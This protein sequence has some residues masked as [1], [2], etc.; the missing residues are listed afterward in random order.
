MKRK[1]MFYGNCQLGVISQ[2]FLNDPK[3]N[4]I[5]E[6]IL[7]DESCAP[8]QVWRKDE[9]LF[10]VWTQENSAIQEEIFNIV[11]EKL[12]QADIFVFQSTE[13]SCIDQLKTQ[14]LCDHVSK[15]KNICIPNIRMF[16]YCS[17]IISLKPIVDYVRTK[18]SDPVD[19]SQIAEYLRNSD[20]SQLIAL[21]EKEYPMSD[22]YHP[23]RN[24]NTHR[25]IEDAK[26]YSYYIGMEDFIRSNYKTKILTV[27]HNHM[28]RVYYAELL[29]RLLINLGVQDIK[30]NEE[31]IKFPGPNP[32]NINPFEFKFF[33][34]YFPE[35]NE[36]EIIPAKYSLEY[37][38]QV[39]LK[40]L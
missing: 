6:V 12:K 2:Y 26:N 39:Y 15:A 17:E 31:A 38:L 40:S 1:I 4:E 14:Y 28:A 36:S 11:N 23:Y 21:L 29:R 32:N 33:R 27:C 19:A 24:Q 3:L 22:T 10:A 25:S 7:C 30:I 5:F 35:L 34:E 13:R 8:M 37:V 9:S 18:V 20:D 16:I